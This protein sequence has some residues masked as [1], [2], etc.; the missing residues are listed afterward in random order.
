MYGRCDYEDFEFVLFDEEERIVD[1]EL[2]FNF[3]FVKK[4]YNDKIGLF[5]NIIEK[6]C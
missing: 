2:W 5:R 3:E 4:E 6:V 1:D